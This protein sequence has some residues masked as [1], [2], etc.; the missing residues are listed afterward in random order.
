MLEPTFSQKSEWKK[1][2]HMEKICI[3]GYDQPIIIA[4][5]QIKETKRRRTNGRKNERKKENE[6][7]SRAHFTNFI[8][9]NKITTIF[10]HKIPYFRMNKCIAFSN[11]IIRFFSIELF[12]PSIPLQVKFLRLVTKKNYIMYE[13]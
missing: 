1:Q 2:I 13:R 3:E 6:I 10:T 5:K 7:L 4:T 9:I 8:S 11:L 12:I